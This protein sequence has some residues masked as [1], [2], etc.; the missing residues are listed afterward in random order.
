MVKDDSAHA[1]L[2]PGDKFSVLQE[3]AVK[4]LEEDVLTTLPKIS[5]SSEANRAVGTTTAF[6]TTLQ[7]KMGL[8]GGGENSIRMR[9]RADSYC[10]DPKLGEKGQVWKLRTGDDSPSGRYQAGQF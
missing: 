2:G 9:V 3:E 7:S 5:T 6:S 4:A 8:D 1:G 10:A